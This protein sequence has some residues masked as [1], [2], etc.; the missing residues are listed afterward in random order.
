MFAL[1]SQ[2]LIQTSLSGSV[3]AL[4]AS[5]PA[6][7][8]VSPTALATELQVLE[9]R[10]HQREPESLFGAKR[11]A[12]QGLQRIALECSVADWDGYGAQPINPIAACNAYYFIEF[13]P[14]EVI[15]PESVPEPDGAISLDWAFGLHRIISL[16]FSPGDRI[17]FAWRD[18]SD[19]GH[20]VVTFD[21]RTIP[22]RILAMI[23]L[24][25]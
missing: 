21:R 16:S 1:K 12:Q 7:G 10:Q 18:G 9:V 23:R 3:A 11:A 13:L 19:R 17:A 8:A 14:S 20:G 6:S 5:A 15:T 24:F 2:R 4:G 25:R 22:A